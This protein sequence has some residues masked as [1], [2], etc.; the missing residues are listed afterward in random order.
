[1]Y[2]GTVTSLFIGLVLERIISPG[3]IYSHTVKSLQIHRRIE[4]A[5]FI[6]AVI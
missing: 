1:M 4:K 2:I 6:A 5:P 3:L